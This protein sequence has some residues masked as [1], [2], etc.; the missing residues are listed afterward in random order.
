MLGDA[1]G[2]GEA[3]SLVNEARGGLVSPESSP[4]HHRTVGGVRRNSSSLGAE[5]GSGLGEKEEEALA[6]KCV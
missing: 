5:R 6:L 4:E 3:V 1:S 2:C